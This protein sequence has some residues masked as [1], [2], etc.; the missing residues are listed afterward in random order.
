MIVLFY[1]IIIIIIGLLNKVNLFDSFTKGVKESYKLLLDLFPSILFLILGI[2]IFL[3]SGIIS[4]LEA[5]CERLKFNPEVIIQFI[6][7]PISNSSSLIMMTKVFEKYGVNSFIGTYSALIQSSI[8]TT[9]YI[10]ILY[11]SSVK[12]KKISVPLFICLV[13]NCLILAI[14]YM[15]CRII[16]YI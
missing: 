6:L 13:S 3:N 4:Y 8:D 7:R 16:Y 1:I 2:N 14:S 10:I 5:F 9:I 12:I 15:I 11:F